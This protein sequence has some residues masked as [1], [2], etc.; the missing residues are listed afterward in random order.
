M[1]IKNRVREDGVS[2]FGVRSGEG[3]RERGRSRVLG[4]G[5]LAIVLASLAAVPV[6]STDE[7]FTDTHKV[8]T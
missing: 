2:W 4:V 5:V 6:R 1:V 7:G 3:G 8:Y